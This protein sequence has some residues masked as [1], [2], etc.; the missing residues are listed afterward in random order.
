MDLKK[1]QYSLFPSFKNWSSWK[2]VLIVF[3]YTIPYVESFRERALGCVFKGSGAKIA[4]ELLIHV[5]ISSQ[6]DQG[7]QFCGLWNK[8]LLAVSIVSYGRGK[9]EKLKNPKSLLLE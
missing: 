2:G 3:G 5:Q 8:I 6:L 7:L 1:Y 9:C 4:G